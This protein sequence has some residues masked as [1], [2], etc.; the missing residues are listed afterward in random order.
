[1]SIMCETYAFFYNESAI[2]H[3]IASGLRLYNVPLALKTQST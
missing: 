3:N 2:L 1:M